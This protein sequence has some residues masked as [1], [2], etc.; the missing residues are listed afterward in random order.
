MSVYSFIASLM[1][2]YPKL[3][4][5]SLHLSKVITVQTDHL[6]SNYDVNIV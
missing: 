1:I 6:F 3:I 4:L 5:K 2:T